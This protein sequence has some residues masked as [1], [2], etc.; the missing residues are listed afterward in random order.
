ML[1]PHSAS[2]DGVEDEKTDQEGDCS[3][4]TFGPMYRKSVGSTPRSNSGSSYSALSTG[5]GPGRQ[6]SG[7]SSGNITPYD[8]EYDD[9]QGA[10]DSWVAFLTF[11]AWR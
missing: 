11:G 1:T 10:T 6:S 5:P 2:G 4:V 7:Q 8:H 3:S 9:K